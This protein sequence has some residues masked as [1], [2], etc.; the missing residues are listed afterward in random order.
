[1]RSRSRSRR[2]VVNQSTPPKIKSNPR[3][4]PSNRRMTGASDDRNSQKCN[5]IGLFGGGDSDWSE[6]LNFNSIWNC[7]GTG[8]GTIS[9]TN[10]K[11]GQSGGRMSSKARYEGRNES[12]TRFSRGATERDAPM[13]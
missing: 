8:A 11:E 12:N 9:P 7:G 10:I 13:I 1:M 3:D 2:S 5:N 4:R 6:A